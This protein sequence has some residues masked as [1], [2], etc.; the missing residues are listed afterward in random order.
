[1]SFLLKNE[2]LS[3]KQ[4][5]FLSK[6][7]T[8]DALTEM[9]EKI[10]RFR[11]MNVLAHCNLLDLSKAFVTVDHSILL[12]KCSKYGLRGKIEELLKSCL[13][14][15]KHFVQYERESSSTKEIECGVPRGSVLGSL[16]FKIYIKPKHNNILLYADDTNISGKYEQTKHTI[17]LKLISSRLESNKLTP[18]IKRN[19]T[20]SARPNNLSDKKT[21]L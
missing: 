14:D 19:T 12:D 1:M 15:R 16:L 6:R 21:F 10:Q 7:S 8:V 3:R 2:V 9:L 11:E 4:F 17:D 20:T 13:K 5:G 18:N